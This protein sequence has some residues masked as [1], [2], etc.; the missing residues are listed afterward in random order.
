MLYE[1]LQSV[2]RTSPLAPRSTRGYKLVL[3]REKK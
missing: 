2:A 3:P 1:L